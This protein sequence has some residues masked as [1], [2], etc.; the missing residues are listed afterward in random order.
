VRAYVVSNGNVM[1]A[2]AGR[3]RSMASIADVLRQLVPSAEK[4]QQAAH[5]LQAQVNELTAEAV[6]LRDLL[7][8]ARNTRAEDEETIRALRALVRKS[9]DEKEELKRRAEIAETER[10]SERLLRR[11]SESQVLQLSDETTAVLQAA[12]EENLLRVEK[13]EHR[14]RAAEQ[15]AGDADALNRELARKLRKRRRRAA[16]VE[17]ELD[18]KRTEV[19]I[20]KELLR[21]RSRMS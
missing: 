10:E 8:D 19:K 12:D 1:P 13:A 16:R 7:K 17:E 15:A 2:N 3:S 6:K 14:T 11:R 9:R 4:E 5:A 20:L 21:E 18:Q